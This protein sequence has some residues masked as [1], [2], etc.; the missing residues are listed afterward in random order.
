MGGHPVSPPHLPLGSGTD[1]LKEETHTSSTPTPSLTKMGLLFKTICY[2]GK[3]FPSVGT[4]TQTSTPPVCIYSLAAASHWNVKRG[5]G[6]GA[7]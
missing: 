2:A 5:P 1:R 7:Q 3:F 6:I 4:H